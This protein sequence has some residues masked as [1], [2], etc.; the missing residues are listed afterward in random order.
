MKKKTAIILAVV[1]IL[2]LGGWAAFKWMTTIRITGLEAAIGASTVIESLKCGDINGAD[3]ANTSTA[4]VTPHYY[5]QYSKTC[6]LSNGTS[7]DTGTCILDAQNDECS[8]MPQSGAWAALAFI[9]LYRASGNEEYLSKARLAADGMID[10]CRTSSNALD[11]AWSLAQLYEVYTDLGKTEYKE[12][13]L[14]QL[15]DFPKISV[16]SGQ[17]SPML[18]AI[19]AREFAIAYR[20]SKLNTYLEK[21]ETAISTAENASLT[22]GIILYQEDDDSPTTTTVRS[23]D[24]WI[25]VAKLEAYNAFDKANEQYFLDA[26]SFF[27]T[28]RISEHAPDFG[29]MSQ[30]LPCIEGLKLLW[31]ETGEKPYLKEALKLNEHILTYYWDPE[32]KPKYDGDG[33]FIS[34]PCVSNV[35]GIFCLPENIKTV[36]DNSF[37]I[38]LL[39]TIKPDHKYAVSK[40]EKIFPSEL[41]AEYPTT[42]GAPEE[43]AVGETA[44]ASNET[45]EED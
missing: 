6:S 23:D 26:R 30:L 13:I 44:A 2:L 40:R 31:E 39:T 1:I 19:E 15:N 28:A 10:S 17:E 3:T 38:Y 43:G 45:V 25:Q 24:C 29:A 11:C 21:A 9:G 20:L 42:G 5:Y 12:F 22:N 36:A 18:K 4:N 32:Q 41:I 7:T 34:L 33:S 14:A 16:P 37:I 27:D 8:T 35:T